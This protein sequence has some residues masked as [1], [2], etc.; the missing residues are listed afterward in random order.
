MTPVIDVFRAADVAAAAHL[1]AENQRLR[2][3]L[4]QARDTIAALDNRIDVLQRAN[5]GLESR[6]FRVREDLTA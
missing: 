6:K 2:A 5:E 1:A 4:R 3:Q